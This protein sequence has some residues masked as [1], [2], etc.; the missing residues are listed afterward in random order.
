MAM[1]Q[2]N[3]LTS[4]GGAYSET[5]FPRRGLFRQYRYVPHAS[6]PVDTGGDLD[7]AG[8]QSGFVYANHDNIGTTAFQKLPR[9]ATHDETGAASLYAAGGEPVEGLMSVAEP[10]TVT[11]ANGGNAKSGT[12]YIW[13]E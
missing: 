10:V 13:I 7:I 2:I 9:Y 3:I 1:Y 12:L 6:T 8:A 5:F 11:I 4:S